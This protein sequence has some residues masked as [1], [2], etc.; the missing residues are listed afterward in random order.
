M[1]G[2]ACTHATVTAERIAS[3]CAIERAHA[4]VCA[5]GT[6]KKGAPNV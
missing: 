6:A 1:T 2:S 3:F 5:I 4:M